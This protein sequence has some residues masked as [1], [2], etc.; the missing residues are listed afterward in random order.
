[1][2][3]ILLVFSALVLFSF[4]NTSKDQAKLDALLDNWHLA[5]AKGDFDGYFDV[6]TDDFVFLGTDPTER[7]TKEEFKTFCKPHFADSS[8]WD[9][10]KINR[11]WVFSE[12]GKIA[13]FDENLDTWM[14]D[15]RGSG[16]CIK[17]GKTWKIAY[18]NLTVLIE[19]DKTKEF[20][21]LREK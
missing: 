11:N 10:K 15:C 1:M 3:Y 9:F 18:Y 7:W 13:W 6:T 2:K 20:I 8:G 12:N 4:T 16:V 14:K 5:A 17:K 19:N 21:Q